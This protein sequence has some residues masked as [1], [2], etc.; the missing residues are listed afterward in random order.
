MTV[1]APSR[2]DW[3]PERIVALRKRLGLTQ[4]EM[5]ESLGYDLARS[6][7]DL[8]N[9]R[10]KPSGAVCVLLD[11]MDTFDGLPSRQS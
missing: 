11:L 10:R 2:T 9:D 5:A 7:S 1:L 3:T 8:E 6:V 4:A